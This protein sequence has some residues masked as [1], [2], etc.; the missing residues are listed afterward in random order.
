MDSDDNQRNF[1][2]T[3]NSYHNVH[4]DSP[5]DLNAETTNYWIGLLKVDLNEALKKN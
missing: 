4:A 2:F 1:I 3:Q 5:L